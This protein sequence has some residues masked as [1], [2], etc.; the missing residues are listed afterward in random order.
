MKQLIERYL[1]YLRNLSYRHS[2]ERFHFT[3]NK[4]LAHGQYM[5]GFRKFDPYIHPD[6]WETEQVPVHEL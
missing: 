5:D 1:N 2:D 3:R 4:L 6:D